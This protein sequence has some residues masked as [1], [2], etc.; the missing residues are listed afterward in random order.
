MFIRHPRNP[1]ITPQDI[2]PSRPDFE[3]IG[4]FNAGATLL[5]DEVLLLVRVAER[6]KQP[7][8]GTILAPHLSAS[9]ELV[10]SEFKRGDARYDSSDPRQVRDTLTGEVLLTSI[11]HLRLARSSDGVH[12]SVEAQPWLAAQPPYEEFGIEDARI[13]Q[14]DDAYY[15]N[16]TAVSHYGVGTSLAKTH[17]FQQIERVGLIF[18]PANRDV[19]LFPQRINGLYA[20]YHRPMPGMFGSMNMWV[21]T[22]PDLKHW[23]QHRRVWETKAGSWEAGRVGGGAPPLYTE[24]GWLSIY[25]A[26]DPQQRYCLGAFLTAHDDPTNVLAYSAQPVLSPDAEYEKHGFFG[27]VVFACGVVL[28]KGMLRV[29]YGAADERIALAEAPL[30]AVLDSL[31]WLKD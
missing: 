28:Q 9:G 15:V 26:A 29:Y 21:A 23:G 18:P 7:A 24:R 11:S 10:I 19:T 16:Y 6:P 20:C 25:H 13:T 27:N 14:I 2:Q 3:V 31:T 30:S 22:S 5:G 8:N 12:F 1:L 17:D 4:T